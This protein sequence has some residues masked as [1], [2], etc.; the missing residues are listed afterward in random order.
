MT[1]RAEPET[2]SSTKTSSGVEA[3]GRGATLVTSVTLFT[4]VPVL[5]S[6]TLYSQ[7]F[8]TLRGRR[9]FF[10]SGFPG[11]GLLTCGSWGVGRGPLTSP[12]PQ[13]ASATATTTPSQL[14]FMVV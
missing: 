6:V 13:P 2:L 1:D 12:A 14:C 5:V 3:P 10:S 9:L 8:P 7:R 4:L 11:L